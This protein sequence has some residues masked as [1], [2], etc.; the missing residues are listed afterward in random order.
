MGPP[1]ADLRLV[2]FDCDGT[3]V[4]SAHGIVAAMEATYAALGLAAP[5]ADAVRRVVGLSLSE[6]MAAL[7]PDVDR[8][9]HDA[10]A[11]TY[12]RAFQAI[13]ERGEHRE[14]LFPGAAE[15]VARLDAHGYLLGIAT[16]KSRRGLRHTLELAGLDPCFCTL[17]TADDAPSKP[18]PEMLRRAIAEC[19]AAPARTV[20]IGDT[21]YDMEM[22]GAAG[23]APIGVTWGHHAAADLRAAGADCVVGSF[24]EL[25]AA[26]ID[27]LGKADEARLQGG[28]G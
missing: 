1:L 11:E 5:A 2:V 3:L 22:A 19:G 21:T 25:E 7:R 27:R 12:R 8:H 26:V 20:M 13:R 6:A 4:D 16:G 10:M 14:A 15:T 24:A 18:H 17:Q 23:V 28:S 9:V